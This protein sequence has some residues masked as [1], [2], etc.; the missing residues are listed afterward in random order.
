MVKAIAKI[1]TEIDAV[2]INLIMP[3]DYGT[4]D[5]P[6]I[7]PG[8]LGDIWN[9]IIDFETR[10]IRNYSYPETFSICM[11]VRDGGLYH[12]LD[13]DDKV[14][15]SIK[16]YYVPDLAPGHGGDYFEATIQTNGTIESW[17]VDSSDIQDFLDSDVC[18]FPN[19]QKAI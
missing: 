19:E 17:L 6:E 1:P 7:F 16:E 3:I 8:R 2:D 4:E 15:T 13:K 11:K 14:I 12:L 18:K 10:R 9:I 5:L